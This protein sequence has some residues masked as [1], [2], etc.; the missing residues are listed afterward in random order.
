[1]SNDIVNYVRKQFPVRAARVTPMNLE[2]L[3]KW[4]GGQI[5]EGEKEG[6]FS[7]KFIKVRVAFPVS[8]RQTEARVGDWL[9]KSGRLFKVYNDKAFRR[10]FHHEDGSEAGFVDIPETTETPKPK[11]PKPGPK[12][13]PSTVI[14]T[15][16]RP[17]PPVVNHVINIV[18]EPSNEQI[19]ADTRQAVATKLTQ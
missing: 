4:C 7:R 12:P 15:E 9:V 18:N 2:E 10:T 6:N 14:Q 11:A 16:N 8:D 17:T 19:L 1:M 13:G 5:K 3:A